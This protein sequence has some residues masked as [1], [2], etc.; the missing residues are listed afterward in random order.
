MY[1]KTKKPAGNLRSGL[2]REIMG[3]KIAELRIF[4]TMKKLLFIVSL[5]LACR[6]NG[7]RS[8]Y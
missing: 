2:S 3:R 5:F 1:L 8:H 4:I 6:G 7:Q